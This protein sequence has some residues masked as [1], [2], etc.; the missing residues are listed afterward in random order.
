[1]SNRA[2]VVH[3]PEYWCDIGAHV[4]P[5]AKFA[6]VRDRLVE[7]GE[8]AEDEFLAPEPASRD[9]LA[10]VHT[11]EY[12]DDLAEL[13]WTRRTMASELPLTAAI[14]RAYQLA[15]GG[16]LLAAREALERGVGVNLTG[17]FHHAYA[18]HAEG[19][20]YINDLAVAIR[21]LQRDRRIRRAAV[22]DLDV[23]QGNGTARIFADEPDVF[24]LSLHQEAN[25][26]V[27]KEKSDLDVGLPNGIGDAEYERVLAESLERVWAF[28]PELLLYQAG[29][30]PFAE[31][32]L[33]GLGLSFAGLERRDRMVL[34][35]AVA[36]GIPAVVTL[37]GG[38]ARRVEDTVRIHAETCRIA[39]RLSRAPAGR[40]G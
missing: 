10:L 31:D 23:H 13:R 16:T 30:D 26:P 27:P 32:L 22:V 9:E 1:M 12:L 4:F 15:A 37:G 5:M 40:E 29:A 7:D 11:P 8:V 18:G 28:R 14:V 36:R 39:I 6:M 24:T 2:A 19:F 34:E 3:T 17:G 21:V 33:G 20:C 38:Y 35:G 25:Y